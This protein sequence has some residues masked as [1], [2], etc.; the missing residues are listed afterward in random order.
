MSR[1][2][3]SAFAVTLVIVSVLGTMLTLSWLKWHPLR[4]QAEDALL[5]ITLE[6][7]AFDMLEQVTYW[8]NQNKPLNPTDGTHS[9]MMLLSSDK[10]DILRV[11]LPEQLSRTVLGTI[12]TDSAVY[13]CRFTPP[14]RLNWRVL[15]K[16]Y[17]PSFSQASGGAKN[18]EGKSFFAQSF[19]QAYAE[20]SS[21]VS[22]NTL[23]YKI[24]VT[25]QPVNLQ[26]AFDWRE[27]AVERV[28]SVER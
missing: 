12:Q 5:H 24:S 22:A 9:V 23:F 6:N 25:A 2:H 13:W 7:T 1:K 27:V 26:S 15:P 17:P 10:P 20:K 4:R 3:G 14:S 19:R 21:P 11:E 16:D 18:S 8:I 28:I